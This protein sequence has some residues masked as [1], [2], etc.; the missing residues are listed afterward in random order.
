MEEESV[1]KGKIKFIITILATIVAAVILIFSMYT[2]HINRIIRYLNVENSSLK[3]NLNLLILSDDNVNKLNAYDKVRI[4]KNNV[5]YTVDKVDNINWFNIFSVDSRFFSNKNSYYANKIKVEDSA[6]QGKIKVTP[7]GQLKDK[8]FVD[9]YTKQNGEYIIYEKTLEII[10][11]EISINLKDGVKEYLITYV[12]L[13]DIKVD[14]SIDINRSLTKEIEYE[15]FPKNATEVAVSCLSTTDIVTVENNSL[16]ANE[17]GET[18]IS[19]Y[20]GDIQ[21]DIK[22]Q[23]NE[24]V[25]EIVLDKEELVLKVGETAKIMATP[26]PG[27]AVNKELIWESSDSNIVSVDNGNV[28]LKSK[29][30][31]IIKV[32][33]KEEPKV[34]KEIIVSSYKIYKAPEEL[35]ID[36]LTYIDGI[37]VVNKKY[38]LPSTFN[39]GLN[40][41]ALAAYNDLKKAANKEGVYLQVVSDFR[42]Y[43]T[44]KY[45]YN[46]YV[47]QFGVG[48]AS[49][50]SAQAGHSEHQTGLAL[51]IST[52]TLLN[53]SFGNTYEGKWLANNCA[54]Y[55]FIIRYPQGKESIT[56]YIYEPWHIRYVGT[57]LA[58]KIA[59]SGLCLE[60]YLKIN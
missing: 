25:S 26:I 5:E 27:N 31:A 24:V 55:G 33:T 1:N 37:L 47:G 14:N 8:A 28:T 16:T 20:S 7:I 19:I 39:P 46:Y 50:M 18:K 10:N 11:G 29:G 6:I 49:V 42:T 40:S 54:K 36:G 44:Q 13:I 12:P 21:K 23:V 59:E 52:V 41:L 58:E 35:D 38:S 48:Y 45:L 15:I 17:A 4:A 9:V 43:S 53:Q 34:E 57:I 3:Y 2:I 51:D 32:M 60:E 22:V 30:Y 56:G